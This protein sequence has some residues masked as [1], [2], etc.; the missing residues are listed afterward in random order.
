MINY[1]RNLIQQFSS[2]WGVAINSLSSDSEA[3][4]TELINPV[5]CA[6]Q[7]QATYRIPSWMAWAY[8]RLIA[9]ALSLIS[10]FVLSKCSSKGQTTK[11]S[12]NTSLFSPSRNYWVPDKL[13]KPI[14]FVVD[15]ADWTV[16]YSLLSTPLVPALCMGSKDLI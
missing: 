1:L 5:R 9:L 8:Q 12:I 14:I 7:K 15:N 2:L 4:I 3:V 16:R 10:F 13:T 6:I 11:N